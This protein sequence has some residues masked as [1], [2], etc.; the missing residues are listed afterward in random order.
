MGP[1][2]SLR[3]KDYD[4]SLPGYYFVTICTYDRA[5]IFGSIINTEN[6]LNQHGMIAQKYLLDISSHFESVNMDCFVVMPNHIHFIL[7]INSVGAIHELL[8]NQGIQEKESNRRQM[9]LPKVVGYY[10]MNVSKQI[11]LQTPDTKVWQ[12]NYYEHVIRNENE[13]EVHREYI[14]NNPLKWDQD[15][16]FKN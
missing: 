4:Y 6:K 2:K 14:Q 10:K 13:L 7:Q 1:R 8:D 9:L 3:L 12:R 11:R 16:Y 15:Q 5:C